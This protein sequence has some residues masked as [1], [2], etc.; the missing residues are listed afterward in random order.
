MGL[1]SKLDELRKLN[2]ELVW[3]MKKDYK[4]MTILLIA[5]ALFMITVIVFGVIAKEYYDV[6]LW[7]FIMIN[8]F[9]SWLN[10]RK[11]NK[12]N[13][14]WEDL[15]GK[16]AEELHELAEKE[17]KMTKKLYYADIIFGI[18]SVLTFIFMLIKRE[19]IN[20]GVFTVVLL[21]VFVSL[22]IFRE[23]INRGGI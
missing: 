2:D 3:K 1:T 9:I 22:R 17:G 23:D 16:T 19:W 10:L 6:A 4:R 7:A 12:Y 20:A 18:I 15:L 11:L 13:L 8:I 5:V 14:L 21:N